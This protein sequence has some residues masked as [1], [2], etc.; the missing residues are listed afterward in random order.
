[1]KS[2]FLRISFVGVI[3]LSLV[4]SGCGQKSVTTTP[5]N[6]ETKTAEQVKKFVPASPITMVTPAGPGGSTDML[7]RAVEKVWNKY[8]PQPLQILNKGGAAGLEGATTVARAKPDGYTLEI[9]Y[10]SGPDLTMPHVQKTDYDPFKDVVAVS[11]LSVHTVAVVVP[12]SSPFKSVSDVVNWAKKENKPV[13]CA[14]SNAASPLDIA[15]KGIGKIAGITVTTVP[16]SGGAQAITTLIGG[17]TMIGTGHPAEIL[18]QIKAGKVRPIGVSTPER[19]P[20]LKDVPTLI[21]Q[22]INLHVWG[23]VKGVAAPA[24]TPKEIISYYSDLFKKI[25]ED[26]DFK[27]AMTDMGQPVMYQNTDD[28]AKFMKTAYDDYGKLIKDLG[29]AQK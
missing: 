5:A 20:Y 23:S 8:C 28:F 18:S 15:A 12:E 7:A 24:G 1:M 27:K 2:K 25:S 6:P 16:H 3:V 11:R 10:G 14:V 13:T 17:N 9:G 29:L 22:G 19:D 21:E 26:A 4:L